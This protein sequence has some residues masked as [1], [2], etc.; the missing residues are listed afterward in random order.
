VAAHDAGVT[1]S[2]R[3]R[4][5]ELVELCGGWVVRVSRLEALGI[6]RTTT[7]RRC[8]PGGQWRAIA[9]G[10]VK[11][12]NA[13]PTRADHRDAA[14]LYA[15]P[16]ALIT[17]TDALELHGMRRM[18]SPSGPV[19]VLVPTD[20]RRVGSGRVLVERTERLPETV[21]GRWPTV[22]VARAALDFT[23][24]CRD[25]NI[26]RATLAEAVQQGLCT[27]AQ[28]RHELETGCGRGSALPRAVL[29]EVGDGV[30]SVAEAEARKL[31]LG[32]ALP[33][34]MWNPRL[35]DAHGG[36]I[37]MPDAWFDEVA[38]AWEIDSREWHLSPQDYENTLNRRSVMMAHGVLVMHT[39]PGKLSRCPAEVR[40]ELQSNYAQ[41]LSRPRPPLRAVPAPD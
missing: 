40:Q 17:G 23:R 32:T 12:N 15:G 19:H 35:L 29:R 39:Q 10:V 41:A 31:V 36:F 8:R 28:L 26:V 24:R 5:D 1:L 33:P 9:P 20:R 37:A 25:R 18:P 14:L 22:P 11:L 34:P 27:P 21:S 38:M 4:S 30:R 7:Q 16:S 6:A 13:P 2:S 3:V